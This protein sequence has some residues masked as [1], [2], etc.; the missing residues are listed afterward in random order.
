MVAILI[1]QN[2]LRSEGVFVEFFGKPASTTPSLA[3]FHLRTGAPLLPVFCYPSSRNTYSIEVGGPVET[4]KT[5]DT[6]QDVL[7][8]TQLCTKIIESQ[9]RKN[10]DF[11]FWFHRRWKSRPEPESSR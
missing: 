3:M 8:I 9:I 7:K 10:P 5:G 2:V 1:D 4:A 6:N 11:W